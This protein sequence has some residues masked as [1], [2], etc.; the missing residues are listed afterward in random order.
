MRDSNSFAALK[1]DLHSHISLIADE[2][3]TDQKCSCKVFAPQSPSPADTC[4]DKYPPD[5]T[6]SLSRRNIRDLIFLMFVNK[7]SPLTSEMCE[8]KS[9]LWKQLKLF[10]SFI[11]INIS[12]CSLLFSYKWICVYKYQ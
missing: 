4:Y 6:I 8:W 5:R 10:L 2:I 12:R 7:T 9:G 1:A 3:L 11:S